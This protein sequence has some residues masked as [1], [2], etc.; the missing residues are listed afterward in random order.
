MGFLPVSFAHI[1]GRIN[2]WFVHLSFLSQNTSEMM[3]YQL[4]SV[5]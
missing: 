2:P 1:V 3:H 5:V 4:K